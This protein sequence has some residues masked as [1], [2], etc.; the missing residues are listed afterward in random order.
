MPRHWAR[1]KTIQ[2]IALYQAISMLCTFKCLSSLDWCSFFHHKAHWFS[3]GIQN[4][5]AR[6]NKSMNLNV[7]ASFC[8]FWHTVAY[9]GI[10][11]YFLTHFVKASMCTFFSCVKRRHV[12]TFLASC[13]TRKRLFDFSAQCWLTKTRWCSFPRVGVRQRSACAGS[14]RGWLRDG[15]LSQAAALPSA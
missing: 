1:F 7:K 10:F 4:Y 13:W 11:V 8:I 5:R 6:R 12:V 3:F 14:S 15:S 9:E 2:R